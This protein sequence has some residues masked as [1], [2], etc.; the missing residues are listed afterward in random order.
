MT[1]ADW[2]LQQ[3]KIWR[4]NNMYGIDIS[5]W[6]KNIYLTEGKYDFAIIKID[7]KFL[8]YKFTDFIS[9]GSV[10]SADCYVFFHF[11]PPDLLELD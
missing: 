9:S 10:F 6:Q 4:G 7:S 2:M 1:G 8:C 11:S 3:N 5:N